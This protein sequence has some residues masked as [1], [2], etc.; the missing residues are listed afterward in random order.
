MG[1][2]KVYMNAFQLSIWNI[3]YKA[4]A[5]HMLIPFTTGRYNLSKTWFPFNSKVEILKEQN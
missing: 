1:C 3:L 4:T 2:C 5:E